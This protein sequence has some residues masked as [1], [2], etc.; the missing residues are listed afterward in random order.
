MVTRSALTRSP[1]PRL[2]EQNVSREDEISINVTGALGYA[3]HS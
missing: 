3:L 1:D 2:W